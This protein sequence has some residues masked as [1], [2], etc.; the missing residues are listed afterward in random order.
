MRSALQSERIGS[1]DLVRPGGSLMLGCGTIAGGG[2]RLGPPVRGSLSWRG[3]I[4]D[5]TETSLVGASRRLA[6]T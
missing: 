3:G 2:D 1:L 5:S 4:I 6:P